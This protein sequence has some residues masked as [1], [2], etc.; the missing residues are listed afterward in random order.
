MGLWLNFNGYWRGV[1]P[2]NALGA[3][4]EHLLPNKTGSLLPR[5]DFLSSVAFYDAL[6]GA[7]R[8]AGFDFVKVDN[9]ANNLGMYRGL[10]HPVR[11]A[12]H[13][14]QALEAACARHMDGLINCMAHGPASLFNTRISSVTRCSEDYLVGDAGRARRH[15]HNSYANIPWLG[16]TV[17]GDHDMFHSNDPAS[18][19]MMAVSKALSAARSTCPT[20]P[21]PS[22]PKTSGRCAWRTG[23]SCARSPRP[24][25]F[26]TASCLT[27]SPMASRTARSPACRRRG[28]PGGV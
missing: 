23:G 3:L 17:W 1:H 15:L 25:R 8:T 4:N 14:Q 18:G 5:A 28:R 6:I 7:A 13:N 2:E 21:P 27:P 22:M 24:R 16:Q 19:R 9:Q 10:D 26:P 12:V 20:P 11:C